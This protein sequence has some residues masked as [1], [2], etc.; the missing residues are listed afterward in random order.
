ML[1]IPGRGRS[2]RAWKPRTQVCAI[3]EMA[4]VHGSRAW[5]CGP[6][7]NDK[8]VGAHERH[9]FTRSVRERGFEGRRPDVTTNF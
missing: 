5:S 1:V 4:S 7:R 3:G 9:F 8:R 6:S 2:P